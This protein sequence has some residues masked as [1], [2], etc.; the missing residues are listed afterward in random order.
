MRNPQ[1][2]NWH[3]FGLGEWWGP[4]TFVD[5]RKHTV[6]IPHPFLMAASVEDEELDLIRTFTT[7]DGLAIVSPRITISAATSLQA[8]TELR[9]LILCGPPITDDFL[10]RLVGLSG[11]QAITPIHT[12]CTEMGVRL[13]LKSLPRC[14]VYSGNE[15]SVCPIFVRRSAQPFITHSQQ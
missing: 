3:F 6:R 14:E 12:C 11:L 15:H 9:E 8:L 13:L 5:L 10:L 7:I 1:N 2:Q 4:F